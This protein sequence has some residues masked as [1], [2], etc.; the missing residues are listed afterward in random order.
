MRER[1]EKDSRCRRKESCKVPLCSTN[2]ATLTMSQRYAN[3][4]RKLSSATFLSPK[5]SRYREKEAV[6]IERESKGGKRGI[7]MMENK[8]E[9]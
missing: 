6:V 5:I 3:S 9:G 1:E 4:G 7:K 2:V 8:E